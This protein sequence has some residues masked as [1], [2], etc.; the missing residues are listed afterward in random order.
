M[1]PPPHT[2]ELLPDWIGQHVVRLEAGIDEGHFEGLAVPPELERAVPRRRL[3]FLAGRYCAVQAIA[4][5]TGAIAAGGG[6]GLPRGPAGEPEWPTGITGSIT[7]TG[8]FVWAAAARMADAAAIGIDSE[9]VLTN[10]RAARIARIVLRLEEREASDSPLGEGVRTTLAFS[11][12]ESLF[13]LLYRTVGRRFYY[14]DAA[15]VAIRR[16]T[17][18]STSVSSRTWARMWAP[19][20]RSRAATRRTDS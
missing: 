7:H 2:S 9:P 6:Y 14:A 1:S 10:E 18:R 5:V 13:K 3:Q 4:G 8:E 16:R 17:A 11:A 15:L 19:D 20:G 12:K